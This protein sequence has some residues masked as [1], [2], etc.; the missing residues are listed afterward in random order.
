MHTCYVSKAQVRPHS[1][2]LF[3]LSRLLKT[4]AKPEEVAASWPG[5]AGHWP[6]LLK[7]KWA[8]TGSLLNR[9]TEDTAFQIPSL[10]PMGQESEVLQGP[11]GGF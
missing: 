11:Q 5:S 7:A 4:P 8:I 10:G 9:S 2:P 1:I 3:P 6:Q